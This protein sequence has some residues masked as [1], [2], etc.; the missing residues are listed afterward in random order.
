MA[1]RSRPHFLSLLILCVRCHTGFCRALSSFCD[2]VAVLVACVGSILCGNW[3]EWCRCLLVFS[4]CKLSPCVPPPPP[5]LLPGGLPILKTVLESDL[6][7]LLTEYVQKTE[8]DADKAKASS[9][10]MIVLSLCLF[11]QC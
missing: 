5:L 8:M 6:K 9:L 10:F 1:S 2:W 11:A 3:V 4:L 7:E